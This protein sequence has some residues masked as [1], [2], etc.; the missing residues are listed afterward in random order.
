MQ[1]GLTDQQLQAGFIASDEFYAT[2]GGANGAWI[3]AVYR[4]LLG[5]P[6]EDGGETFWLG[7]LAAGMSRGDVANSIAGSVENN[8]QLI[9]ADY[10]QYLGRAAEPEGL[11]FWLERFADGATNEDVIAGF[12][13]SPE[14]Y[15]SHTR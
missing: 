10:F 15:D 2:A 4:L 7:K 9:N 3:D 11:A 12:T 5:R 1:N 13:G 14:Y 8:S 6:P